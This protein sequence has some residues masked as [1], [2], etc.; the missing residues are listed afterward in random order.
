MS[1]GKRPRKKGLV[2]PKSAAAAPKQEVRWALP[3]DLF[4]ALELAAKNNG[5]DVVDVARFALSKSLRFE[6]AEVRKEA[7]QK[8]AAGEA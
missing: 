7:A 2:L 1:E 5:V 8:S 3:G 6:L 4:A